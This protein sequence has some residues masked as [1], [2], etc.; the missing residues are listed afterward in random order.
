[1]DKTLVQWALDCVPAADL[2]LW[3]E[4][5]VRD[6]R[7]YRAGFPDLVQFWPQE[8]QYRMIEVKGPGDRVQDNQ[9]RLLEYCA[10]HEIPVAVCYVRWNAASL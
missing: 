5:I 1:L 10:S 2:R 7:E 9:R 3:F 4:C 8:R 6:V